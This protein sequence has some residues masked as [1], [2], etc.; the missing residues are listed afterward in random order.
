L[1]NLK[2]CNNPCP[3]FGSH[4]GAPKQAA[5]SHPILST[6]VH[7]E[8]LDF[9]PALAIALSRTDSLFYSAFV[10]FITAFQLVGQ[11]IAAVRYYSTC[12]VGPP[13]LIMSAIRLI[14]WR[15][16][17][18][19]KSY[20]GSRVSSASPISI[21]LPT[22][23]N[24]IGGYGL[25]NSAIS[26][27]T[28]IS[29][30]GEVISSLLSVVVWGTMLHYI[31]DLLLLKRVQCIRS[32]AEQGRLHTPSSSPIARRRT[33]PA[34]PRQSISRRF[35][36]FVAFLAAGFLPPIAQRDRLVSW[37]GLSAG[38]SCL[39]SLVLSIGGSI[40]VSAPIPHCNVR[41][42]VSCLFF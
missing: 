13:C 24:A 10:V 37:G 11:N 25:S 28:R 27:Q 18:R 36:A 33:V 29:F 38:R 16:I 20:P 1:Q 39:H 5:K 3:T 41:T 32:P 22:H 7:L 4:C 8:L 30:P 17:R 23:Q 12:A 2:F 21:N 14:Q 9:S 40:C 34:S 26:A 19:R 6:D 42:G 31:A 15:D 35:N